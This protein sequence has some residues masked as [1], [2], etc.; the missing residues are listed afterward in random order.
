[1]KDEYYQFSLPH[2]Y[3]SLLRDWENV[4]FE[5]ENLSLSRES[6]CLFTPKSDQF[7][8][9]PAVSP[10]VLHHTV[11]RTWLFIA[12]SDKRWLYYQF[13]LPHLYI[14][15]YEGWENASLE[16][17]SEGVN[18]FTEWTVI[19]PWLARVEL[20]R[21]CHLAAEAK[22]HAQHSW[23]SENRSSSWIMPSNASDLMRETRKEKWIP[24]MISAFQ[25]PHGALHVDAA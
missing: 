11:C 13:S 17:G 4:R 19:S 15:L 2:S 9:S 21:A 7:Q 10:E 23:P 1:M 6:S 25:S 20:L 14:F 8:I 22:N 3:L 16:L 12:Y 5:L 18:T 24:R